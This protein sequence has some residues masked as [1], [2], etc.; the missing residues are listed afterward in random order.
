MSISTAIFD[1]HPLLHEELFL[2]PKERT[3]IK[4]PSRI[5]DRKILTS[6]FV[7]ALRPHRAYLP[8]VVP[9]SLEAKKKQT[10]CKTRKYLIWTRGQFFSYHIQKNDKNYPFWHRAKEK[11]PRPSPTA[12]PGAQKGRSRPR[13]SWGF[14]RFSFVFFCFLRVFFCFLLFK[15][16]R[17]L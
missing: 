2:K 8:T 7:S 1:M 3:P 5:Q 6:N 14:L 17:K 15:T 11:Q 12:A 4:L 16:I 13:F 10:R 9:K